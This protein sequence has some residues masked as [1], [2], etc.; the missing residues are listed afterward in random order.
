MTTSEYYDP[1]AGS[2]VVGP[3][4]PDSFYRH[5]AAKLNDTIV[6]GGGGNTFSKFFIFNWESQTW[7]QM[8]DVPNGRDNLGCEII[9]TA[10]GKELWVIGGYNAGYYFGLV[11]IFNFADMQWSTGVP[12]PNARAGFA[13]VVVDNNIVVIGGNDGINAMSSILEW[14]PESN[15]WQELND[16]LDGPRTNFGATLVDERSGVSCT[17]PLPE[18]GFT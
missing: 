7:T 1:A 4:L 3:T 14:N 6:I 16:G 5:C 17:G 15:S 18:A 12:L 13:T 10:N 9:E 2:F 11:D 8:P